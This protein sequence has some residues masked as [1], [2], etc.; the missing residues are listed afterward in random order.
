MPASKTRSRKLFIRLS[1]LGDVIL[2]MSALEAL[3]PG[4]TADWVIAHAHREILA[5]HPRIGQVWVFDPRSGRVGWRR[6]GRELWNREYSEIIDLH[7]SLRSRLLRLWF[8]V[9]S[10]SLPSR[11]KASWRVIR[12]P[13]LRRAGY[14]TFKRIW[15]RRWR[16]ERST[17][18]AAKLGGGNG[19]EKPSLVHLIQSRNNLLRLIAPEFVEG[20]YLCVMPGSIWAGKR[21]PAEHFFKTLK[22]LQI[23]AVILGTVNDKASTELAEALK[24]FGYPF[25]SGIGKWTLPEVATVLAQS[26][27]YLGNDTGLAHLAEAVGVRAWVVFGPT[28]GDLGFGPWRSESLAVESPLWCSPCSKD[29]EACFRL[30]NRFA[31]LRRLSP[32][33]VAGEV[34]KILQLIPKGRQ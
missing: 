28:R 13:R 29:G 34:Q 4:E 27:G 21:W 20:Q 24:K 5:N 22:R 19:R 1:S 32:E 2:A 6:L 33:K 15:P 8:F 10:F 18:Q 23:P 3:K 17:A 9:W 14:F 25:I 16:P 12:K 30:R 11:P 31:C 7:G 26:L